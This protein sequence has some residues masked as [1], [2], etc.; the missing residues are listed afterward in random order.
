MAKPLTTIKR[1]LLVAEL[2]KQKDLDLPVEQRPTRTEA[3]ITKGATIAYGFGGFPVEVMGPGR[4]VGWIYVGWLDDES[5][6]PVLG[7]IHKS[8]LL[9]P[10]PPPVEVI[11]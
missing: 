6:T 8:S 7:Q 9:P 10:P 1:G 5:L 11:P 4:G 2:A 3:G